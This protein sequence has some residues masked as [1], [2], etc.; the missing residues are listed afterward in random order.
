M[1]FSTNTPFLRA[2]FGILYSLEIPVFASYIL[3][4]IL[5]LFYDDPH[6]SSSSSI[7]MIG[8]ISIALFLYV[9]VALVILSVT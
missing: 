8:A 4:D 6:P 3:Y 1:V 7:R 2:Y 5:I 9:V